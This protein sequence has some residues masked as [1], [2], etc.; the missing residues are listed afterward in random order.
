MNLANSINIIDT[1]AAGEPIRIITGGIPTLHGDTMFEKMEYMEKNYDHLRTATMCEPRGHREMVGA[2]LT[3]PTTKDAHIGL[4]YI[5]T[6]GYAPMCGAGA[7]AVGKAM[8][9]T[10]MVIKEEPVTTVVMDTPSGLI[11][12]YVGV[13][14]GEAKSV[15]FENIPSFLYKTDVE[16]TV[17][18]L[19]KVSVDIGYGGNFFVFVDVEPLGLEIAPENMRTMAELG[20]KILKA[21]NDSIKVEHPSKTEITFLNDLMFCKTPVTPDESYKNFV[22]FGDTQADRSPCG[23]GTC[24]RMARLHAK[25]KLK[26]N[27]EF[28]HESAIGTIF[29]GE[30]TKE[31]KVGDLIGVVP[32]VAGE[33]FITGFNNFVID[34]KDPLKYGFLV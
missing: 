17:Q 16:I 13:E 18:D 20:M 9:E 10:G 19:G 32:R 28:I 25:G 23:T 4:F 29:K 30:L 2:V 22:V 5:D 33:T 15:S 26:L 3:E 11:K 8:V 14:N 34:E 6:R 24:A 31:E 21:A 1:H 27:E 12:A 7:L